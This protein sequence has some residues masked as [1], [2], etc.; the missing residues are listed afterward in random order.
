MES[1]KSKSPGD[2]SKKKD[3]K[4]KKKTLGYKLISNSQKI[5]GMKETVKQHAVIEYFVPFK[6]KKN[7]MM[8]VMD[9]TKG[10]INAITGQDKI[11][12]KAEETRFDEL[13]KINYYG[14]VTKRRG[15]LNKFHT[16][17]MVI[18]GFDLYWFRQV[19]DNDAKGKLVLPSLPIVLG[20]KAGNQKCFMVDKQDGVSDSRK[21]EFADNDQMKEF[22]SV[23]SGITQ[24]KM[25]I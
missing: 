7:E 14:Y 21:L 24:L 20:I 19:D 13:G 16:R 15:D 18:R 6:Q 23:V 3:Q 5:F 22:K 8:N 11:K 10:T 2:G 1:S 4:K 9:V 17:W 12:I 25:Y